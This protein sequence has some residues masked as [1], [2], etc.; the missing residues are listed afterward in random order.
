MYPVPQRL[1]NVIS[2]AESVKC[3]G[4]FMPSSLIIEYKYCII[5]YC[6]LKN[7]GTHSIEIELLRKHKSSLAEYLPLFALSNI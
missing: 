1:Q 7:A 6:S 2:P 5:K 4:L 3:N